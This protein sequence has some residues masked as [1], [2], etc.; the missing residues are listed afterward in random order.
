MGRKQVE[1]RVGKGPPQQ[2]LSEMGELETLGFCGLQLAISAA[3][4][5]SDTAWS[6]APGQRLPMSKE[7]LKQSQAQTVSL[8]C[9][10]RWT[11]WPM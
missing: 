8:C 2:G 7:P 10:H 1:G 6:S 5:E 9:H 3:F 11:W 4:A